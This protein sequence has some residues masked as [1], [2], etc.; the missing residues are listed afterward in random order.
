M[1]EKWK[2]GVISLH[3][4]TTHGFPNMF[5]MPAPGQQAVTTLNF[6]HLMVVGAEHIAA[7]VALLEERGREGVRRDARR[8]RRTGRDIDP[9]HCA[10]QQRVHGRVHTV[11]AELRGQPE[12]AATRAAGRTAAAT[13]TSSGSATSSPNGGQAAT[14]RAGSST[15]RT[16]HERRPCRMTRHGRH[17][18]RGRDRRRD[19]R[20][21]RSPRRVRRHRRPRRRGRRH[22]SGGDGAERTTAERIVDAGGQARASNISVT[23]AD[24][25]RALFAELV[26]EFGALDAVVNVAGISRP[27]G[28]AHGD[29]GRLAGSARACT[30]TGTSTCSRAALPLMAAAGHGRILGVTSGSGMAR[31]RRRRL[32]LREACRRRAHVADRRGDPERGDGQRPVADRGDADGARRAVPPGRRREHE[33]GATPPPAA[34]RSAR[35]VPPPEHLGPVGAYLAGE[36]FAA[37]SRGQIMFS[38]GAEVAWVVP[39]HLLEVARD[40]R[41]RIAAA[42]AGRRSAPRCSHP[43]RPR[44]PATAAGT[45]VSGRAFEEPAPA[46]ADPQ[47]E[48]RAWSS[49]TSPSGVPRSPTRSAGGASRASGSSS[50]AHGRT[51][52]RGVR[53]RAAADQLAAAARD[54]GPVDAVVV[55]LVGDGARADATSPDVDGWQRVL[56]EHAGITDADP[57]RR[58]LGPRGRRPCRRERPAGPDRH[59]GRRHDRRRAQSGPGRRAARARRALGDVRPGR[60]VRDQRGGRRRIGAR[61]DRRGRR[62]P[63]ERRRHRRA[64]RAPSSSSRRSGSACAATRARPGRSPSAVP[65]SP[66]G[67]TARS[68]TWSAAARAELPDTRRADGRTDRTHRRRAHPPVGSGTRRLVPVPRRAA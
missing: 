14:S 49:P 18:R 6:T 29:R 48:P 46:S 8:P 54:A 45:R 25:V 40:H 13:A 67:S 11:A 15:S 28:F 20:G 22:A 58:G 57:H 35:R 26:E 34:W 39:P 65:T 16:R 30:S 53:L 23:D 37:W 42:G 43:P 64:V 12:H 51:R 10:R 50:A 61:P 68:A 9:Q 55:A 32:Q 66:T 47:R 62:V 2:D 5:I 7:T 27:T 4:M 56:D 21:A 33:P 36:D 44:R 60:R 59:R 19:R 1:E 63:G 38:N 41:R 24:A 3:G 52:P 17:R 31:G